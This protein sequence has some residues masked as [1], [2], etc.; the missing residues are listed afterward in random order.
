L[1]MMR[2]LWRASAA[3]GRRPGVSMIFTCNCT[4][5]GVEPSA[6]SPLHQQVWCQGGNIQGTLREHRGR[7]E[8]DAREPPS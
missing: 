3:H 4:A 7:V 2:A 1:A 5:R 6:R 8:I